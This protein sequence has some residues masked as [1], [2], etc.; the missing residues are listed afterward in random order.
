MSSLGAFQITK[1]AKFLDADNEDSDDVTVQK[2]K[3]FAKSTLE[4][5]A[6]KNAVMPPCLHD[7]SRLFNIV[8]FMNITTFSDI[9]FFLGNL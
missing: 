1:D 2:I 9:H 6:L 8:I 7:F 3:Q 5:S 4:F